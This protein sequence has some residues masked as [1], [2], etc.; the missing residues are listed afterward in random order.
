MIG[1]LHTQIVTCQHNLALAEQAGLPYE[2]HLHRARLE[3]LKDLAARHGIDVS[4]WIDQP[5]R[6]REAMGCLT[7][8]AAA[9]T[10]V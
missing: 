1:E 8:V 9:P 6:P 5:I 4:P 3:D 7:R 2:A 10:H